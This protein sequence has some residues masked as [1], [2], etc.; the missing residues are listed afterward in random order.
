M[1]ASRGQGTER[2]AGPPSPHI[3]NAPYLRLPGQI[4]ANGR[5]HGDVVSVSNAQGGVPLNHFMKHLQVQL[6]GLLGL[7]VR[8]YMGAMQGGAEEGKDGNCEGR[9][10]CESGDRVA[11]YGAPGVYACWSRD[12]TVNGRRGLALSR[13]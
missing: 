5:V 9:H 2:E 3:H 10:G 4:D 1:G 12:R 6:A 8:G 11:R 7:G 13:P